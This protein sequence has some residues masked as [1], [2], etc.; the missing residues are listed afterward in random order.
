LV[1]ISKL[2]LVVP[3]GTVTLKTQ[4]GVHTPFSGNVTRVLLE[5]NNTTEPPDGADSFKVTVPVEVW[6]FVMLVGFNMSD[7]TAGVEE[8]EEEE[9]AE[10]PTTTPETSRTAR[11]AN[12]TIVVGF[13]KLKI[14]VGAY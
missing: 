11:Q 5:V 7:A 4:T 1:A 2:A 6:P 9:E 3:A 12:P 14:S 8:E 10:E 13:T